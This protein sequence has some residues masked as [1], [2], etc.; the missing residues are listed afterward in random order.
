MAKQRRT[1]GSILEIQLENGYFSYA[2]DL[3]EDVVFFD[4]YSESALTDFSVLSDKEP[5]FFL[6][7]YTHV[8]TSGRWKKVG[9]I[10][11]KDKYNTLPMK[12]IQDALDST[13]YSLYNTNTGEITPATR[14]QCEGLECAAVWEGEHVESRL[15]DYY[16]GRPNKWVEDLKLK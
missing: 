13:R 9:K 14:A 16:L 15:L 7:V 2:Q 4:S 6:G 5:L 12:F 10:P 11:I 1:K 8:I 3:D